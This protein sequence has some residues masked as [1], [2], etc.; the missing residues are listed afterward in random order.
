MVYVEDDSYDPRPKYSD[1]KHFVPRDGYDDRPFHP[2]DPRPA[3]VESGGC[4]QEN[5]PVSRCARIRDAKRCF[6]TDGC[7]WDVEFAE[8]FTVPTVLHYL[9]YYVV[10]VPVVYAVC[11][12][13]YAKAKLDGMWA[14]YPMFH[15]MYVASAVFATVALLYVAFRVVRSDAYADVR[16]QYVRPT[17]V[18]LAGATLTPLALALWADRGYSVYWTFLALLLTSLGTV[19]FA[20]VHLRTSSPERR[21]DRVTV[22]ALMYG[23]FH[24]L[25]MDNFVWWWLL[26]SGVG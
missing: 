15:G 6:L 25:V 19:W 17:N 5:E 12:Y 11:Y 22:A 18:M 3:L 26:F 4:T 21:K 20:V 2:G 1:R 24:V 10:L 14:P 23:V 8:C 9:Q 13:G 16:S 7:W